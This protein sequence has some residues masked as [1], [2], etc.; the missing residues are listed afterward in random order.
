[1]GQNSDEKDG[2]KKQAWKVDPSLTME[3]KKGSDWKSDGKLTM[4]LKE[5]VGF[6]K[7]A[8]NKKEAPKK[9]K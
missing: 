3:I 2:K 9:E 1:M 5:S 4:T 7:E 8:D 6:K